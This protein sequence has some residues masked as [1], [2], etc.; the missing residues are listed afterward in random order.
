MSKPNVLKL[1]V[2]SSSPIVGRKRKQF[3]NCH[4]LTF[5]SFGIGLN[6]MFLYFLSSLFRFLSFFLLIRVMRKLLLLHLQ[7]G[8][9]KVSRMFMQSLLS[10]FT[11]PLSR[12]ATSEICCCKLAKRDTFCRMIVIFLVQYLS[13]LPSI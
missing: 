8:N 2:K 11:V 13:Y 6:E 9:V 5:R 7:I 12:M 4:L 3:R 10:I 1:F